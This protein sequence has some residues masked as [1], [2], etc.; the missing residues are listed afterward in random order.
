MSTITIYPLNGIDYD[1][2][3]AA[4]YNSPRTSGVYSSEDDFAVT[5]AGGLKVTVSA[6][7]GW[8]HPER[9]AGYSVTMRDPETVTMPLANGS[10]PRIDLLVLRYD[11]ATRSSSLTVLQGTAA[12]TPKAPAITRTEL[13][14]DLCFAQIT[15]PAGSTAITA[16]DIKDTRTDE[17]LCGVM[18]DGVK[19]LP[20]AQLIAQWNAAQAQQETEARARINELEEQASDSAAAADKSAKAAADSQS[21]AAGSASTATSKASA[22]AESASTAS[23]AAGT[24]TTQASTATKKAGE[25]ATSAA[26][27]QASAENAGTSEQNA[28]ASEEAAARSA[29]AAKAVVG[30]DKTLTVDG[31]PADAK[32]VGDALGSKADKTTAGINALIN[33]LTAGTAAPTDNDYIITQW[34]NHEAADA[35]NQNMYV[36]RPVSALWEYIKS[37]AESVF[38]AKSHTHSYAG[39]GSAG[40]SAT[41]AVKLDTATAGSATQPVY[42]TGGKPTACTY[43][44]GKSVPSNAVFTDH[45]YAA[46]KGATSSAAG[47]AG[48]VPAP[49]AGAQG[50][51]LRGDGTWQT[52]SSS[53][54]LDAWPVGSIYQT[55]GSTSPASLFGGTWTEIASERVLMGA[56]SSH[57]AG[58]TVDA[59]LP[60]ITGTFPGATYNNRV[61]STGAFTQT[62][63]VAKGE[64]TYSDFDFKKVSFDASRSSSV[65]GKSTTVQ[66]AAYYVHIWRRTA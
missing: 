14:Y 5:A 44:L 49:A 59:G 12:S 6:G 26:A 25:A 47:T 43:T 54:K 1:A 7:M 9:F 21:A 40:G 63:D 64:N 41:S 3:D 50:K 16:A 11:A 36:R 27:A 20:T 65:Y 30:A 29:E 24:A 17:S 56:S 4:A 28:K 38:A 60:N 42:F 53:S 15:R 39:S 33:L 48:L 46:M 58:S 2:A 10:L 23:A 37:K 13:V 19:S 57:T 32:V 8:I 34:A 45:T 35:A 61:D 55:T 31:A 22:A 51:F 62:A 66:P 52:I 18:S